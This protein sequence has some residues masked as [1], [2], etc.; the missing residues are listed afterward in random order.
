LCDQG[1]QLLT[2]YL[3]LDQRFLAVFIDA[4]NYKDVLGEINADCHNGH[5]LPLSWI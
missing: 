5:G 3:G 4:E 2:R 1:W